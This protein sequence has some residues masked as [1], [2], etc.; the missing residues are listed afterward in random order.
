MKKETIH[1]QILK[2]KRVTQPYIKE[3]EIDMINNKSSKFYKIKNS[4]MQRY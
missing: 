3:E 4:T 2:K 1:L